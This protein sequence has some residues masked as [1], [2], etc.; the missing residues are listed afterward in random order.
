MAF[1]LKSMDAIFVSVKIAAKANA[2]RRNIMSY[3]I[4]FSD[5]DGTLLNSRHQMLPGTLSAIKALRRQEIPFVIISA[6]SPSGI[7]PILEEY[8]FKSPVISYSGALIMDE[9][10]NILYSKGFSV[11]LAKEIIEFIEKNQFDCSW[12]I[13]SM[14]T[15]IVKDRHDPRVTLEEKIV[16][17]EATEGTVERLPGHADI[18]KILCM[19]NP[20]RLPEIEGKLKAEFPALS[21]A[22]SSNTLLEIMENGVTKSSGVKTLCALW[23]IPL[24][25]TVA[26]GDHYNDVEM[27]ETVA[28]PFLMGNAPEELKSRF[29][30]V[31]DSNDEEGIYNGLV[32]IGMLP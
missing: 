32:K 4:V 20:D 18:G 24:E 27:L 28:M 21:I 30:N 14:D 8:D 1:R 5:V 15:W 9:S 23:N 16:H 19:C 26:F 7:Y 25:S 17:A 3:G 12:N 10:R 6:R 11:E 31:T 29:P 13:Y 22:K 2:F